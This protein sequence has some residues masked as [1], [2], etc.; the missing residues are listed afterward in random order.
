MIRVARVDFVVFGYLEMG[1]SMAHA[2]FH[3]GTVDGLSIWNRGSDGLQYWSVAALPSL[4]PSKRE[5]PRDISAKQT[6]RHTRVGAYQAFNAT[7]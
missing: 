1:P 4:P 5:D 6:T 7:P 2:S 3:T